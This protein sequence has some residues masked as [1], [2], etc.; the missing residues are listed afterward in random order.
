M[1]SPWF[2]VLIL[3]LVRKAP[4]Q[5][6]S[7][8]STNVPPAKKLRR[9]S[10]K[11]TVDPQAQGTLGRLQYPFSPFLVRADSISGPRTQAPALDL[12]Q[13]APPP[14][15]CD[16]ED[17]D[18]E[19]DEPDEFFSDSAD[20]DAP[21]GSG[22]DS[23]TDDAHLGYDIPSSP[24]EKPVAAFVPDNNG[25]IR[26]GP[27]PKVDCQFI[28]ATPPRVIGHTIRNSVSRSLGKAD[29][30]FVD[31]DIVEQLKVG[32]PKRVIDARLPDNKDGLC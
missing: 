1:F 3:V 17:E 24:L 19:G 16:D 2:L 5:P 29:S 20:E 32:I 6:L 22:P 27:Q 13:A 10:S 21:P 28:S 18:E 8:L 30:G 4:R 14:L 9:G 23:A 12:G 11:V 15:S 7:A 26:V 25:C 31:K